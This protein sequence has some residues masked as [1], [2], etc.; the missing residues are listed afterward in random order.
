[1]RVIELD[2][3]EWRNVLDY[4]AALKRSLGSP[5]W[6]GDSPA[7][8][9]DSMLYGD[10]NAVEPPYVIRLKGTSLCNQELKQKIELLEKVIRDAREWKRQHYGVDTEVS[11]DI[12]P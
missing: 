11:F 6:H 1:M 8:W 4:F 2:A 3:T 5:A 10:I 7:A 9:V 12:L